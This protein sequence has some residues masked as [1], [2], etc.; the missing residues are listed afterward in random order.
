VED[1]LWQSDPADSWKDATWKA[2]DA[3]RLMNEYIELSLEM[4]N[5]DQLLSMRAKFISD[6]RMTAAITRID[7]QLERRFGFRPGEPTS[8]DS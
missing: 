1:D 7:R 8:S 5:R 4:L 2:R 6:P 3:I